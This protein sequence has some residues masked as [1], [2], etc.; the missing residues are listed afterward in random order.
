M[1]NNLQPVFLIL[2]WMAFILV[3]CRDKKEVEEENVFYVCSMDP[4]VMERKM[5]LCPIC[6]MELSKIIL[7]KEDQQSKTIVLNASQE[8]L[9]N[10]KTGSAGWRHLSDELIFNG[11]LRQAENQSSQLSSRVNGR[12]EHLLVKNSGESI[13]AGQVLYEI[14]SEELISAQKEY[15]LALRS[16]PANGASGIDYQVLI[17]SAKNRLLLMGMT[18]RQVEELKN[19]A[20]VREFFPV[21]SDIQGIV[22]KLM[23]QEG[24][25]IAEGTGIMELNDLSSLWVE[26]QLYPNEL[27]YIKAQKDVSVIIPAVSE[28]AIA[29]TITFTN[30]QLQTN[31]KINAVRI[32]INNEKMLYRPGMMARIISSTGG[33]KVLAVPSQAVISGGHGSLIWKQVAKGKFEFSPVTT[34]IR[35]TEWTEIISGVSA[36]DTIVTSGAYLLN[37]AYIF[38]KGMD[39]L[40]HLSHQM[41]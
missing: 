11:I 21:T 16:N 1:R 18:A 17:Q 40:M 2:L 24:D 27:E 20:A 13:Q 35:N 37:S 4:Q 29:G 25:Y 33:K 9:A 14:Y 22:T 41:K 32:M 31:S 6:K 39:P 3:S 28:E 15:Q 19:G 8:K 30:P 34:G 7:T 12:V 23:I 36:G 10:I 26:G 38:K 5:G